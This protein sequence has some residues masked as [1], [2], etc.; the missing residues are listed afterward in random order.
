MTGVA[1]ALE[2]SD[3]SVSPELALTI[4]QDPS[5]PLMDEKEAVRFAALMLKLYG[6]H[7]WIRTSDLYRVKVAL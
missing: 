5:A 7:D 2:P 6:R 3:H 1:V 4:H